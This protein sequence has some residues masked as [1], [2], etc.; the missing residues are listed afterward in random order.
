MKYILT[1]LGIICVALGA[2]GIVLPVLPTTPF[3]LLAAWLFLK[4]SNRLRTWLIEHKIFGKYIENYILYKAIP[5]RAKITSI[6]FLWATI[7]ISIYIVEPIWLK[8]LLFFIAIGVTIHISLFK[9]LK[10]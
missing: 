6:T 8:I 4:S 5:L 10:K 2:L 1:A 7:L 9:T 3:L